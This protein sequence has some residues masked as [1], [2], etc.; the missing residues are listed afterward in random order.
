MQEVKVWDFFVRILHWSLVGGVFV[1]W[2][3]REGDDIL[4]VQFGYLVLGIV[5]LRIIWGFVGFRHARFVDFVRSPRETL[6]WLP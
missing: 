3:T 4:H 1:A 2:I 5:A 6:R